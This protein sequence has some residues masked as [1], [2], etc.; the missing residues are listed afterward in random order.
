[1]A[2]MSAAIK[3]DLRQLF[4]AGSL[5]GLT[6]RELLDRFLRRDS[7]SSAAFE[8]ILTRH[9]PAVWSACSLHGPAAWVEDAFQAT[10]LIL[11]PPRGP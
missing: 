11:I 2:S 4:D 1:M 9:G 8:A 6:D 7:S 10:F 5:A 3:G